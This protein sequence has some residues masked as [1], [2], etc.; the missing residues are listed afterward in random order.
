MICALDIVN[1]RLLLIKPETLVVSPILCKLVA[2]FII[3]RSLRIRVDDQLSLQFSVSN[4]V[5]QSSVLSPL[6]FPIFILTDSNTSRCIIFTDEMKLICATIESNCLLE[7]LGCTLLWTS[8][9]TL[10]NLNICA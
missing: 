5:T 9:W 8:I 3:E 2:A 1:H 6:L 7:N 4:G 10:P